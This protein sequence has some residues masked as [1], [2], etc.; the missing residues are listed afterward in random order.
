M[1]FSLSAFKKHKTADVY[2]LLS[3]LQMKKYISKLHYLTQDLAERTHVAQ[4]QLACEAGAKWIQYRCFSKSDSELLEDL[5]TI[6]AI[7]DDWG[8]TL[9]V[10]DHVHLLSQADIQG[11]HIEDMQADFISVRE[12]IGED[13]TLGASAN[14]VDDIRRIAQSGVVDYIG[15]GP[16]RT[17]YTKPNNYSLLGIEGYNEIVQAMKKDGIDIPLIAVGGVLVLDIGDLLRAGV[18]GVAISAAINLAHEP[19]AAYKEFHKSLH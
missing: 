12:K 3:L 5:H 13:K 1:S 8:A 2:L 6:S 9:L 11:V 16:L 14:T 10:T 19:Q 4:V 18:F 17:T 15:C 7:C